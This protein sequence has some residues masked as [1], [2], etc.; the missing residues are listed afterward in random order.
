LSYRCPVMNAVLGV[1]EW[2][3]GNDP[4]IFDDKYEA[5]MSQW[6]V[7]LSCR[8]CSTSTSPEATG[9]EYEF[10][11]SYFVVLSS[12]HDSRV[13]LHLRCNTCPL[14]RILLARRHQF[15]RVSIP[16]PLIEHV[17]SRRALHIGFQS[18][19]RVCT[20][21]PTYRQLFIPRFLL[22]NNPGL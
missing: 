9:K 19:S 17:V 7:C 21:E 8:Q 13:Q 11:T 12:K 10:S 1:T 6:S 16:G 18:T 2:T 3:L 22:K 14:D 4:K 5:W 20:K 15:A